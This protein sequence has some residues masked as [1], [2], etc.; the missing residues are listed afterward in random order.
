MDGPGAEDP[1]A[2][3]TLLIKL[4]RGQ[5]SHRGGTEEKSHSAPWFIFVKSF[6]IS[7]F[8]SR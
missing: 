6:F 4:V 1:L 3:V 7:V 8:G 2:S 5:D